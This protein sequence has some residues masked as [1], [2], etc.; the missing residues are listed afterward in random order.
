MF[1]ISFRKRVTDVIARVAKSLGLWLQS[2]YLSKRPGEKR[3]HAIRGNATR[4][5][6][7]M[8]CDW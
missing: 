5:R 4:V 2:Q 6:I 7:A 8:Q 1:A 3:G